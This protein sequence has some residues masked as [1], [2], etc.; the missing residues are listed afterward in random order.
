MKS[1]SKWPAPTRKPKKSRFSKGWRALG[2]QAKDGKIGFLRDCLLA[3]QFQE[4]D[5]DGF[6]SE[7]A[8]LGATWK[9]EQ[10][11]RVR[12]IGTMLAAMLGG[13]RS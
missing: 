2:D 12:E 7:R 1:S 6:P 8:R 11:I 13:S 10:D 5:E 3:F 9:A 4:R